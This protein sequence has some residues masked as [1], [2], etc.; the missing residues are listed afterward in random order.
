MPG[1]TPNIFSPIYIIIFLEI[2]DFLPGDNHASA[3]FFKSLQ[4]IAKEVRIQ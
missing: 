3:D 1:Y 2:L 4:R